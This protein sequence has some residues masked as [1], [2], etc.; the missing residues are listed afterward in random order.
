M[1]DWATWDHAPKRYLDIIQ[2][3]IPTTREH[4]L[5]RVVLSLYA[6]LGAQWFFNVLF[7]G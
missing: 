6:M 1:R 7:G 2:A 4:Q 5:C 3:D